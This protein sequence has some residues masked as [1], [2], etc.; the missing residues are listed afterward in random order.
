MSNGFIDLGVRRILQGYDQGTLHPEQIAEI[1]IE[2][3]RRMEPQVQAWTVFDKS[4]LIENAKI[5]ASLVA[6][7][8]RR[9]LEGIPFGVKDIFNTMDFQTEMGSP[10]WKG[11]MP[12][13]DARAVYNLK[14]AGAIVPGKT[15]TA[16]FA[17]HTLGQT[18]NPHDKARNPGTSSSGSAAAV[19]TGMVPFALGTQTAGSIVRPA[20]FCGV[21]GY[22]PS[23]G[24]VPR[25]GMLKTTDSL[26]TVGYF[27]SRCED[28]SIILD[29]LRVH[30]RDYP[31]S[32]TALSD[33]GRQSKPT[34]RP[35]RVAFVKTHTWSHVPGYAQQSLEQWL[36]GLPVG[37]YQVQQIDLPKCMKR[38][39]E[40]HATIYNKALAYYFKEE[41]KKSELV[42]PVMQG[43]VQ[44]G[45][46]IENQNYLQALEEQE[47]LAREMDALMQQY[48][49]MISLSTAGHAPLRDEREL[50]DPAL[51]WT[52]T[53][54]PVISAPAFTSPQ[55]LPFGVQLVARRY[56]DILLMR[57]AEDLCRQGYLPEGAYPLV[58]HS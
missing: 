56:N 34:N 39:H 9:Q 52:M 11:F 42:S 36:N 32:H 8:K 10:I 55:G 44:I 19:A 17:V 24:L 2:Q 47:Q 12:G 21:Y 31:I 27:V 48:D 26:D 1:C 22:K 41:F 5:S 43:L 4:K 46:Q 54:L 7:G 15:V 14:Q 37:H 33:T 3:V 13:N 29:S 20:S 28:I 45:Q 6:M 23:F 25:T 57:F 40:I 58:A 49:V 38:S 30:G 51:M 53:H 18:I 16:E 50:D 35:W